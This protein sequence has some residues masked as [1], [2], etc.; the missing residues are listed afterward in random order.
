MGIGQRPM[1]LLS[2]DIDQSSVKQLPNPCDAAWK[3]SRDRR[4][5]QYLR[6]RIYHLK[7][8]SYL[9]RWRF[10]MWPLRLARGWRFKSL[11]IEANY[12]AAVISTLAI[13]CVYGR[14]TPRTVSC[15]IYAIDIVLPNNKKV[16]F[17]GVNYISRILRR[18]MGPWNVAETRSG[19]KF[20]VTL[21][22]KKFT[23]NH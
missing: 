6:E 11:S 3:R 17:E 18:L 7:Y 22:P 20:V 2:V 15:S 8:N 13:P 5:S 10:D 16:A 1:K 9:T 4:R 23:R 19:G 14:L 12:C 21:I